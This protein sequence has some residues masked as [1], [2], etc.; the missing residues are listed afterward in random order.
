LYPDSVALAP[1]TDWNQ[2]GRKMIALKNPNAARNVAATE[3]VN[4]RSRNR[5]SGTIGSR[6]RD[7]MNRNTAPRTSPSTIRPPTAG[8]VQPFATG[9]PSTRCVPVLLV[10]PMRNVAIAA[11]NTPAPT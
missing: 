4:V 8:S 1:A 7:S 9:A 5:S 3:I 2:R 11:V 10:R 6:T